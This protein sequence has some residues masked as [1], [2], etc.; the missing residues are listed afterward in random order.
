MAN[1]GQT[2]FRFAGAL[3]LA[4]GATVVDHPG[5]RGSP[6][7]FSKSETVKAPARLALQRSGNGLEVKITQGKRAYAIRIDNDVVGL[8]STVQPDSRVD[9]MVV[10]ADGSGKGVPKIFMSNMRVLA[11]G[12]RVQHTPDGRVISTRI[13][14]I[15][16]TPDEAKKLAIAGT[17]GDL[18]LVPTGGS[19]STTPRQVR[20]RPGSANPRPSP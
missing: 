10:L 12:S 19:A 20:P 7:A 1:V 6:A 3:L 16:V 13:A 17:Q 11:I 15:E 9:I 5:L 14:T 18:R 2:M 8:A 4:A